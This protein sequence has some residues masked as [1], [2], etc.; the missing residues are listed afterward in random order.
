MFDRIANTAI[1]LGGLIMLLAPLWWLEYVSSSV[2][3]L[4]IISGFVCGFAGVMTCAT[5]NRPFEAVASVAA[6]TRVLLVF[7]QIDGKGGA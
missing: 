1:V 2:V 4:K 3:R 6:Y 5:V 7:M